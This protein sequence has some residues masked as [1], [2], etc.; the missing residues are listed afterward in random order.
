MAKKNYF[1]G[2]RKDLLK[3]AASI[4][5]VEPNPISSKALAKLFK[6][7]E[8]DGNIYA[9]EIA[10]L[11][12]TPLTLKQYLELCS[13]KK[14]K[15]V[16]LKEGICFDGAAKKKQI[17][18]T[19]VLLCKHPEIG[20]TLLTTLRS[21]KSSV[22]TPKQ[23]R[24]KQIVGIKRLLDSEGSIITIDVDTIATIVGVSVSTVRNVLKSVKKSTPKAR[25]TRR[26]DRI[27]SIG[28]RR[29]EKA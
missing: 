8:L 29:S 9:R 2:F 10:S 26:L 11:G 18:T 4:V 23:I 16:C 21:L 12:L 14:T 15:F 24:D 25:N 27:D 17:R 3:R 19:S 6:A 7:D 1:V 28:D 13:E 5:G 20:R 22:K